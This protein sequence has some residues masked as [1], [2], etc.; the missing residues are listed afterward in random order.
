MPIRDTHS[1][2]QYTTYILNTELTLTDIH[3]KRTKIVNVELECAEQ[4]VKVLNK[5]HLLKNMILRSRTSHP[6]CIHPTQ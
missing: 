4:K 1:V 5:K 3:I 2:T 6:I